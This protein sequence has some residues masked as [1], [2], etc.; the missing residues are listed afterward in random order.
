MALSDVEK[1]RGLLN[2]KV[3]AT[4]FRLG[5]YLPSRDVGFFVLRYWHVQWDLTGQPPY[6]QENLPYPCVNLVFERGRTLIYGVARNKYT[7]VLAGKGQVFGVK[8]RPGGFYPFLKSSVAAITDSAIPLE[9]VFDVDTQA[10][11]DAVLNARAP[12]EMIGIVERMLSEH[13]PARDKTVAVIQ[14]IVE[15]I[16]MHR[17]ITKVDELVQHLH[18]NKRTLQRLFSQYVGVTPKTVIRQ[19]RMHEAAEQVADGDI[20]NWSRLA[21]ELGYYDQ[22]HFIKDF[23]AIIGRTPAA[24]AESIDAAR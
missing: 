12:D 15:H 7:E 10:L 23:K 6:P 1:P 24:Y 22:A 20:E 8:F 9:T 19:Y 21:Q 3:S 16:V 2:P 11:E 18:L 5:R 4:K 17:E 14:Q 13:L